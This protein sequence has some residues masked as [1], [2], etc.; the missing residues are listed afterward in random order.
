[1][2][3]EMVHKKVVI[4]K[5]EVTKNRKVGLL[6]FLNFSVNNATCNYVVYFSCFVATNLK[7]Q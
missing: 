3:N 4:A 6:L 5:L 2:K 7:Y 1:L